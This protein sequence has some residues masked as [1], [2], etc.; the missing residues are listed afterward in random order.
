M[1]Q[2]LSETFMVSMENLWFQLLS[3]IPSLLGAII[4]LIIGLIIASLLGKLSKKLIKFTRVDRL[5]E[6]TGLKQEMEL[7]GIKLTFADVIGWLVKWFF[8]IVTFIAV[9]DILKIRQLTIF[10]ETM[11]LYIPNIIIA[12]VILTLGLIVGKVLKNA[13]KNTLI[14]MSIKEKPA[15]FLGSLTKWSILIFSF[16]AALVQLGIAASL[17]QT[18]FTGLI[19]MIALAAG[20]AFGLGGRE[21]AKK[22]L[23]WI[24]EEVDSKD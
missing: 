15:H 23:N 17:I 10:L 18:L 6:K 19:L 24:E 13:A 3:F 14:R 16:M 8:I 11:V 7:L 22:V 21:H 2:N 4:V 12:V 20:L 5:I 9:V 1:L